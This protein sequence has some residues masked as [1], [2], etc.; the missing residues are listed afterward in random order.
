[1]DQLAVVLAAGLTQGLLAGVSAFG[2]ALLVVGA[3]CA[4]FSK[5]AVNGVGLISVALYAAVLPAKQS[6][7][8][9]LLLFLLG[10][11]FAITAYRRHAD[12]RTL[13][14]LAPSVVVGVLVGAYFVSKVGDGALRR[15]IGGVLLGLVAVHLWT[16]RAGATR[17]GADERVRLPRPVTVGAGGLAGFTSMVANAGGAVMTVYML[18][19]GMD[20]MTFLG[21]GAWFFFAVN[22]FKL[23]FSIG[24][25]LVPAQA[26]LVLATLGIFVV[27][28]AVAGR[29]LVP[30]LSAERFEQLVLVFTVLA[31]LNLVR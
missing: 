23:P 1:V 7:G 25:G 22:L 3:L 19:A 6:T 30:H 11:L 8:T 16:R 29:R 15:S 24:L 26:L 14:R 9:L 20:V 10:D 18:G 5:T 2:W 17:P 4:G 12:W 21:T 31:A 13:L 28:G 27:I